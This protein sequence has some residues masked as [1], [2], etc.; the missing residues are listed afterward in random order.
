[1]HAR[2]REKAC[3]HAFTPFFAYTREVFYARALPYIQTLRA[4]S[5]PRNS[6]VPFLHNARD[7]DKKRAFP[8]R[9][10]CAHARA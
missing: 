3:F 1:M 9:E 7:K 10:E 8:F 4:I 5:P 6:L 2:R